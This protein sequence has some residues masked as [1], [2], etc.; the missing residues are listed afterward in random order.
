MTSLHGRRYNP[1]PGTSPLHDRAYHLEGRLNYDTLEQELNGADEQIRLGAVRRVLT[2]PMF[3]ENQVPRFLKVLRGTLNDPSVAV[4]YYA[5]KAFARL[6][7]MVR[8]SD[9]GI[10][11][12]EEDA[13]PGDGEAVEAPTYVYGSREYWLYE[14]GSPD[15]KFRIKG[16]MELSKDPSE[17]SYRRLLEMRQHETHDHVLATLVKYISYFRRPD[18]FFA[19]KDFLD[20]PDSRVRANT[21]EGFQILGDA[22][23]VPSVLPFL[24]DHDNRI[25]AN[26]AKFLVMFHPEKVLENIR[27]MLDS[28]SEWMKDS[29]LYLLTKV[30]V[31]QVES[32]L[33][34]ALK[35]RSEEIVEKAVLGLGY[36]GST[37]LAV[38]A[39]TKIEAGS[40]PIGAEPRQFS[41][42]LKNAAAGALELLKR[43]LEARQS[44]RT[45]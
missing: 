27:E 44:A 15:Y 20:H 45:Q 32:L 41:D 7:R 17:D 34:D 26:A 29:A 1:P 2:V 40:N 4:R 5:K 8:R 13:T 24:K 37:P 18:T 9:L 14:L 43:R 12:P 36:N 16:I 10:S 31:P 42:K 19:I 6:K 33:L 11:M 21:I 39:L 35:D 3:E 23:A 25:R 22:R 38:D 30:E 28:G